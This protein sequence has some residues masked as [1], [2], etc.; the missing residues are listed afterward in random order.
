MLGH[1]TEPHMSFRERKAEAEITGLERPINDHLIKL[2]AVRLDTLPPQ[3]AEHWR[4]ELCSWLDD[5][6]DIRLKPHDR[7]AS[8][9][10][11]YRILFDE[12]FGGVE[13]LN[14]GRRLYRIARDGYALR[15]AIDAARIAGR[16]RDF[17]AAF[18]AG[19]AK[20]E[21][22]PDRVEALVAALPGEP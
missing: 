17:H 20:G 16:L 12:R 3:T 5:I 22:S 11:Y 19:C 2:L 9:D 1:D 14:V 7:P 18:A 6:A 4:R 8:R 15:E 13:E 10:F 21:M